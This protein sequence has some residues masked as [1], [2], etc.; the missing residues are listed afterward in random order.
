MNKQEIKWQDDLREMG[1]A[2]CKFIYKLDDLPVAE[3]HHILSGNR[4]IGEMHTIGLCA[5]HHRLGLP[6]HPSR[7]SDRG[8]HGGKA[9]FEQAY[10]TEFELLEKC[11]AWIDGRDY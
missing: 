4:R 6:D 2:V 7:H 3:I 11:E 10:G 5:I 1:C 8:N 9:A